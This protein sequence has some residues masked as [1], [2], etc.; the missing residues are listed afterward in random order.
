MSTTNPIQN[1]LIET[2]VCTCISCMC[3]GCLKNKYEKTQTCAQMPLS[4]FPPFL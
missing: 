4:L 1:A 2:Y 3:A